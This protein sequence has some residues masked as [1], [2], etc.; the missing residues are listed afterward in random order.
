[1]S[2]TLHD[3]FRIPFFN[4]HALVH[5]SYS[6]GKGFGDRHVVCD[7]EIGHSCPILDILQ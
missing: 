3:F 6:L 4:D 1:M 5:D 2:R 7:K